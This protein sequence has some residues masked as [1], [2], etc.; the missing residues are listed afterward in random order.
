MRFQA[1]TMTLALMLSGFVKAAEPTREA[2][3]VVSVSLDSDN[4]SPW[5]F[6]DAKKL[7]NRMFAAAGV[8][9]DWCTGCRHR[10][11]VIVI[12]IIPPDAGRLAT[13]WLAYALPYEGSRIAL[14]FDRIKHNDRVLQSRL[15]AHVL[16]H[17]ITHILQGTSRHSDSGIMKANWTKA[18][19]AAMDHKPLPFTQ[20]DVEGIHLGLG[21]RANSHRVTA[22]ARTE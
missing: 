21:K 11:G 12:E 22:D 9:I 19:F 6:A 7:A 10:A 1:T 2:V 16:V 13:N 17:E 14:D 8:H 5:I 4:E 20:A 3:P 18:D 15:L